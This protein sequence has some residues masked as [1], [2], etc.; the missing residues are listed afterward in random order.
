MS[1]QCFMLE[2]TGWA[3]RALRRFTF[4]DDAACPDS[5][6]GHDASMPIEDGPVR[7]APDGTWTVDSDIPHDDPRWPMQCLCGY[8]F[9]DDDRWQVHGEQLWRAPDGNKYTVTG[10]RDDSAP[11]GA[12]W[13]APWYHDIPDWIGPDGR[14]LSVMLPDCTAWL[15]DGPS[16]TG[17]K[18]TRTG[19]VPHVTA[20]PS[21]ASAGYHGFLQNG[22]LTDDLE[23]RTYEVPR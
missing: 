16:R 10:W 22:V 13:D 21:I 18:W 6:Y 15:I 23:G 7:Y 20:S 9:S 1:W 3:R 17:G 14:S 12:M 11:A 19:E 4:R 5:P 8:V 2:S